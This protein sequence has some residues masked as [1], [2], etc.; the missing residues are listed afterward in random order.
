MPHLTKSRY[1]QALQ[2]QK[3]LWLST[4]HPELATPPDQSAKHRFAVGTLV[5]ELARCLFPIGTLIAEDHFHL[6]EAISS[7]ARHTADPTIPAL[8]E[9]TVQHGSALCRADIL[10][11]TN[12][13]S[14]SWDLNEVKSSSQVKD[15]YLPDLAFQRYCFEQ[16]GYSINQTFLTHLNKAYIRQGPLDLEQ[17]FSTI[18]VTSNVEPLLSAVPANIKTFEAIMASTTSP[19]IEPGDQCTKPYTCPYYTYCNKP[20]AADSVKNLPGISQKRLATF[21]ALGIE[22]IL[23]ITADMD[24]TARQTIVVHSYRQQAPIINR[25]GIRQFLSTLVYPLY[26]FDFETIM[27]TIPLFDNSSPFQQIPFQFSLHIQQEQGAPCTHYEFLHNSKDDPRSALIDSML[28]LLGTS[29]SIVAYNITFEKGKIAELAN[30]DPL[31]GPKL[32][33]LLPRFVDL[34]VPF[35]NGDYTHYAFHGSASLKQ[36]LPVLVPSLSYAD[37]EIQE[38]GTASLLYEQW[39]SN[40]IPDEQWQTIRTNLL[41]YCKRDTFAMVEIRRVLHSLA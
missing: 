12:A 11:R 15:V 6:A 16:A 21:K 30:Y 4:H 33:A 39:V 17:L 2:C 14:N 28:S 36:V 38:G 3:L 22:S 9:A 27:P 5:G 32:L 13:G 10:L 41:E 40:Q 19:A 8:F 20:R 24:L 37:L 35:R 26:L 18:D 7:T 23:D 1:L 31:H 34:I 29:G 25:N